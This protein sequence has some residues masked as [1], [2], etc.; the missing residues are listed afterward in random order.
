MSGF[1][2]SL[3]D[4]EAVEKKVENGAEK[5]AEQKE[6]SVEG[7]DRLNMSLDEIAQKERM[8]RRANRQS[9]DRMHQRRYDNRPPE[10]PKYI[11]LDLP[12]REVRNYVNYADVD[13]DGYDVKLRL[14]L[15]KRH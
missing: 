3:A 14:V 10:R 12:Q 4:A 15:T 11:T 6:K 9:D 8:E 13:T 2:F 5:G 7:K 1:D